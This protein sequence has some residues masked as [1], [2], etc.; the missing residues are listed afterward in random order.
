[1]FLP[2]QRW[3]ALAVAAVVLVAVVGLG[4]TRL[5]SGP[6]EL[7][8]GDVAAAT[9]S[10]DGV[11]SELT[12]AETLRPGDVVATGPD[13][14]ATLE[15]GASRVRLDGASIVRLTEATATRVDLEQSAG[16]IWHRVGGPDVAY[17]VRTADVTWTAHGTAF[18]LRL[19]TGPAGGDAWVRGVGIEHDV[20]IS[21]RNLTA[22][23][24]QGAVG[25]IRLGGAGQRRRR[26]PRSRHG[27]RSTRPVADR[28]RAT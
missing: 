23:L 11:T 2:S 22:T 24:E 21:G 5:F 19:E 25:R 18:D 17:A 6:A 26:R 28:Q 8:A 9:L 27:N 13:G 16:R 7:R 15:L 14:Y 1:M 20:A 12:A 4:P 10:R 3:S